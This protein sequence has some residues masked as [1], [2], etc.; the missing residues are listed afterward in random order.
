LVLVVLLR[1]AYRIMAADAGE[2]C[3]TLMLGVNS[4]DN[5]QMTRPAGVFRDCLTPRLHA[6]GLMKIAG[7][8]GV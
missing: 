6:N 7:R 1:M 2:A 8:E 5:G 3:P 4:L